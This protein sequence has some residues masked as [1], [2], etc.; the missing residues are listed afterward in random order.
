G[1][2]RVALQE[3]AF[4][5]EI[6]LER[7]VTR[8]PALCRGAS[9][10]DV[11]PAVTDCAAHEAREGLTAP[12]VD[13]R[14]HRVQRAVDRASGKAL[15]VVGLVAADDFERVRVWHLGEAVA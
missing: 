3:L 2:S 8:L 1:G 15:Q 12:V 14:R 9:S 6:A 4:D 7:A 11:E 5:S 13:T 10:G